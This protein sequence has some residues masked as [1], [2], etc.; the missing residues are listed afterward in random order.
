MPIPMAGND[1]P[2]LDQIPFA[3]FSYIYNRII[4]ISFFS[5]SLATASCLSVIIDEDGSS[6]PKGSDRSLTLAC[7]AIIFGLR[8]D[9]SGRFLRAR[10][11][12]GAWFFHAHLKRW[13][14][15]CSHKPPHSQIKRYVVL[16]LFTFWII[17][18]LFRPRIRRHCSRCSPCS[19]LCLFSGI[20]SGEATTPSPR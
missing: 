8:P 16:F 7:P 20:T 13:C 9:L 3:L 2:K 6:D 14:L 4:I 12:R 15:L 19:P 10:H 18:L 11:G 5:Q 1:V 17:R